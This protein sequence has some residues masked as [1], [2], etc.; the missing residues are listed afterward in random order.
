MFDLGSNKSLFLHQLAK[1]FLVPDDIPRA[2][3]PFTMR[4]VKL[5][6]P[7]R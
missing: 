6:L 4:Y 5:H 2:I 3:G 7:S 1:Q